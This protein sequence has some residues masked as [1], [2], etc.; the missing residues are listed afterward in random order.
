MNDEETQYKL[1]KA[2]EL[3]KVLMEGTT[4]TH[5]EIVAGAIKILE[6]L[7]IN[8]DNNLDY[9]VNKYEENNNIKAYAP[10][11]LVNSD[12]MSDTWL[13][14]RKSNTDLNY[15]NRYKSY[16]R[17]EDFPEDVIDKMEKSTE[18][19]LSY[20]ADPLN[21]SWSINTKKRGLVIGDVQSG[22]TANYLSLINMA[23]DY[24][25]QLI[26]LLAGLTDSLRI[27]TQK[28]VDSGFV[29]A[30]SDTI[31]AV[32]IYV[33]VG[34]SEEK[35]YAIP[36]TNQKL[37]FVKFKKENANFKRSDLS[38]PVIMVVKKNKSI[39]SQM[40]EWVKPGMDD[41]K[42]NNILIVDDEADNAS[43]N[44]KSQDEDPSVINQ[45]I[46]DIFNNF[47][48]ASYVGYTATPFA[49]VFINP[50]DDEASR[51]L[52]PSDFIVQLKEPDGYF[53]T[54]KALF[55]NHHV[56]ILDEQE[57]N[58]LPV[59]HNKDV[60]F[61][62]QLP[63]S[64][65]EALNDFILTNVIRTLK[66]QEKKHRTFMINISR[67]NKVQEKIKLK[68]EEYLNKLKNS[69]E[70]CYKL[71]VNDF[72]KDIKLKKLYNQY[73]YDDFY[74]EVR[75]KYSWDQIQE[76]LN[77]E[78]K[79]IEISVINNK[80]SKERYNYDDHKEEGARLIAIGGFVLSRGLTL[81]GLTI[82][83][84]S[85]NA[86]AY[87]TML[88]MCRWF[89][90]RKGYEEL[91]R[92]YISEI[93][94]ENY[95]AIDDAIDDL[96]SQISI[97]SSRGKTPMEFGLMVKESPDTLETSMLI[98]SRNKMRSSKEVIRSL[99]YS[100]A[101]VDTPK[102]FKDV[103]S[104][105]RNKN[106]LNDLAYNLKKDGIML[107]EIDG[108]YMFK[109]V[110]KKYISDF[111][112][113]IIIPI[114]NRKFDKEGLSECILNSK[115]FKSWDIVVA[116]GSKTNPHKW[117]FCSKELPLSLRSFNYRTDES[118]IRISG[119]NNRLVE[120]G[121]YNSGLSQEQKNKAKIIAHTAPKPHNN[122]VASDYLQVRE[123]PLLVIYPL[124]LQSMHKEDGLS[125]EIASK[126]NDETIA[127]GFAIGFP[128]TNNKVMVK[129]RANARKL[130]ELSGDIEDEEDEEVYDEE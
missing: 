109:N 24:G 19:I 13:Y 123:K 16:L 85:R 59:K 17:K 10:D 29:G 27:Q 122:P 76:Y 49:N 73:N 60:E 65:I 89:G 125:E 46:R 117:L 127:L 8:I 99:N 130:K 115:E 78:A 36:M 102:I 56:R 2:Y 87:D 57:E 103:D 113:K 97:M 70:Q 121:I 47:P 18:K 64:L 6:I 22:K 106:L 15:F 26:I 38:K 55:D 58:F 48:I 94:L 9:I 41:I 72:C 111:I 3:L 20:C 28:R 5:Q 54:K 112:E 12:T 126:F 83:Y 86:N 124:E 30:Q 32:E 69:I 81:E 61:Y 43:I 114:E 71:P 90:Y 120:P 93:N 88:Q 82:S 37:D 42:S 63:E 92:I 101:T 40:A 52:F 79:K 119:G 77:S 129:Y 95:R 67:F 116:T 68:I 105:I 4:K 50:Y 118:F 98:T 110:D 84:F 45:L 44:T 35:H 25:Y 31:G 108:R 75:N 23:A 107:E 62:D 1:E 34:T 21:K 7:K 14:E 100:G 104:N 51:D 74:K 128:G 91:C 11:V 80:N 39:L 66:G 53:G 96:K 33:G